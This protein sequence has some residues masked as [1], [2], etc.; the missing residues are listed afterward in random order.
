MLSRII[1]KFNLVTACGALNVLLE[2]SSQTIQVKDVAAPKSLGLLDLLK[3]YDTGVIYAR[4]QVLR[5]VHVRQ[6]LEFVY[7]RPG[8]DEELD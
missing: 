3:A 4:R 6:A 1:V 7:K 5:R 8:L 2:P